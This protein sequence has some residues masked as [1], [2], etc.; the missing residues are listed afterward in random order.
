MTGDYKALRLIASSNP[1]IR[2]GEDTRALMLDV[3]IALCPALAWSVYR[4]GPRALVA[5]LIAAGSAMG[6]EWLY[7]KLLKK[8]QT[9]GDFSAAVTGLLLA[10]VCPV[11]LPY[12]MLIVGTFFAIVVVKQLYGGLGK[13]FMNPALA[14][15]AAL[16]ACYASQMTTWIDPAKGWAPL[17]LKGADVVTAATP[18]AL[19]GEDFAELADT[20]NVADMFIGDVGGS[21]GEISAMMLLIGGAYLIF[22]KVISWHIPVAYIGTVALL[23]FLFPHGHDPLAFMLYSVFG[24][25]LMLGAFFMATDYVTSPVTKKGQL[26]FGVGCGVLT[27]FIRTFGSFPEGVCYSIL[28]MN[29]TVWIIDRAVKPRRFG[30]DKAKKEAAK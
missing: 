6:W 12:W 27:I 26:I 20:Y 18:M 3:I 4:F 7:R 25:G 1:H 15:R 30:A 11:T 14:G 24:G 17:S 5:A 9:L 19:L 21:A 13:N 22:R 28:L 10:M 8:P 23:A 16:V 2:S 29:C